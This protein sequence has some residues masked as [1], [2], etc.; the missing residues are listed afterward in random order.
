MVAEKRRD[1]AEL[2][3]RDILDRKR[4]KYDG[5]PAATVAVTLQNIATLLSS[6]GRDDEAVPLL[7]EV[8]EIFGKVL[9]PDN[10]RNAYP[11][12]TLSRIYAGMGD[13][14]AM[15]ASAGRAKDILENAVPTGHAAREMAYCRHGEALIRL[16]YRAQGK[17]AIESA[18]ANLA[19]QKKLPKLYLN[20]C[21]AALDL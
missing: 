10:Y 7:I 5:E 20:E 4:K 1:E 3:Y 17:A 6:Q 9:E 18:I 13:Y 11:D 15:E 21:R 2:I 8:R 14:V 16:G 19:P 12:L